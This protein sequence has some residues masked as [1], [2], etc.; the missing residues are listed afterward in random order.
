MLEE[1]FVAFT[2]P[3]VRKDVYMDAALNRRGKV[4]FS[5][6]TTEIDIQVWK[7]YV[8]VEL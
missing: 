4:K 6:T 8:S 3:F 2:L 5:K 1:R 7:I